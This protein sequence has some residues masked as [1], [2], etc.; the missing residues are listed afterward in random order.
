MLEVGARRG[1]RTGVL[2][3]RQPAEPPRRCQPDVDALVSEAGGHQGYC[4]RISL[5]RHGR[6]HLHGRHSD[7][8]VG[9]SDPGARRR[10]GVPVAPLG[11]GRQGL[12]GRLSD[13][14]E[15]M[16]KVGVQDRGASTTAPVVVAGG[17]PHEGQHR[18]QPR[19]SAVVLKALLEQVNDLLIPPVSY[20][21]QR[22]H[23]CLSGIGRLRLEESAGHR[24]GVGVSVR[25]DP[26]QCQGCSL[27]DVSVVVRKARA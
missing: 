17:H 9:V 8:R 16:H 26:R 1:D 25:G 2:P 3:G 11:D 19:P 6:E 5:V 20:Q 18:C 23:S 12:H 14:R 10:D 27:P 4:I 22:L 24:Q 21:C 13:A 15:L 7:V